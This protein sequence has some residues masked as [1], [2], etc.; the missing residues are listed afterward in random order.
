MKTR[1]LLLTLGA[2]ALMLSSNLLFAGPGIQYWTRSRPVTT[3]KEAD[4]LK[5]DDLAVMV[6]GACKTVLVKEPKHVGPPSK[7]RDEWFVIGSKHSCDHCGGD[8]TVVNGKTS[9]SMEHNCSKCGE[10]AAFCCAVKH[11]DVSTK[12]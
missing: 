12:K 9:D 2:A 7:G 10:G 3:T 8:M 6:C 5:P 11:D 4:A 1:R